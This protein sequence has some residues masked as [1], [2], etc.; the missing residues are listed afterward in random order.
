MYDF[1]D[2]TVRQSGTKV[3]RAALMAIQGFI[4]SRTVFEEDGS[5]VETNSLEQTLTTVFNS[6]GSVTETFTGE[7]TITLTTTFNSDGSITE[8]IS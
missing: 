2:R 4:S 1:V 8:V 6:D 7:K 5:V 3:N